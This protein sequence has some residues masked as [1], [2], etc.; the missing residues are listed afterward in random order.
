MKNQ[1][2]IEE[3]RNLLESKQKHEERCFQMIIFCFTAYG[4]IIGFSKQIPDQFIP[5]AMLA[6]LWICIVIYRGHHHMSRFIS[7]F[8]INKYEKKIKGIG[9]N[10][11]KFQFDKYILADNLKKKNRLTNC[12]LIAIRQIYE[13]IYSFHILLAIIII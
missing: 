1:F 12:R 13:I 4:I 3:Y 7:A 11:H 10:K 9:Y 2:K 6:V 5:L 8:V